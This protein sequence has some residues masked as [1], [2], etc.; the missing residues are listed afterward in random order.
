MQDAKWAAKTASRSA[1]AVCNALQNDFDCRVCGLR[2][3]PQAEPAA[4]GMEIV[5]DFSR[6]ARNDYWSFST[7]IWTKTNSSADRSSVVIHDALL[8]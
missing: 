6:V 2:L 1:A 3:R 4:A 8:S 7:K 5:W